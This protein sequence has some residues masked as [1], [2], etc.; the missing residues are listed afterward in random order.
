M[1]KVWK[2]FG[3]KNSTASTIRLYIDHIIKTLVIIYFIFQKKYFE[4]KTKKNISSV[5]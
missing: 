1:T 4:K 5:N 3:E 2:K